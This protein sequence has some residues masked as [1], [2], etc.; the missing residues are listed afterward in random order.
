MEGKMT[1]ATDDAKKYCFQLLRT[2]LT[3][4]WKDVK[5][6]DLEFRKLL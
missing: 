1:N 6:E 2:H 5:L 3:G 4:G